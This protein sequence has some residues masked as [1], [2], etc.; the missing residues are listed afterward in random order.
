MM[1]TSNFSWDHSFC[2]KML[3]TAFRCKLLVR[4]IE[5]FLVFEASKIKIFYLSLINYL[6]RFVLYVNLLRLDFI[7]LVH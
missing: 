6:H 3:V 4:I 5:S 7:F 2:M 1:Y